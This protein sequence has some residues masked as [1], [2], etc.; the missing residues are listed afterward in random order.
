MKDQHGFFFR[1]DAFTPEDLPMERLAEYMIN[2]ARLLGSRKHVH[3]LDIKKGS[4]VL[5]FD[6]DEPYKEK[7]IKRVLD[8]SQGRG[9]QAA[10]K[11]F[12][13]INGYLCKDK[14][15]GHLLDSNN[16]EI[17]KFPGHH[18]FTEAKIGPF[19]QEGSL[20]GVVISVG[21]KTIQTKVPVWLQSGSEKTRCSTDPSTAK[22]LAQHLLGDELRVSGTERRFR[23]TDGKWH[24]SLFTI[25]SFKQLDTTPLT[26]L[27]EQLRSIPGNG[28]EKLEDP[29]EV[30]RQERED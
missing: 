28:W 19:E 21:G 12:R 22:K 15:E 4:F 2:L 16:A 14:G 6:I 24:L 9:D 1:I 3:T 18:R 20:D 7:A 26:T 13:N 8:A 25:T 5:K 29:W 23:D 27:V 11:A 30:L 17:I 10:E